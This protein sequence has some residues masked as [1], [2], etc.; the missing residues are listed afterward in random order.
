MEIH[1]A[2]GLGLGHLITDLWL[3]GCIIGAYPLYY[4]KH[5]LLSKK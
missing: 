3:L 2:H 5:K 4:I 1:C